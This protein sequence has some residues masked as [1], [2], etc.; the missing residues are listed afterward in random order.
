VLGMLA[1]AMAALVFVLYIGSAT[2]AQIYAHPLRL[3]FAVP[4]LG[5]WLARLWTLSYQRRIHEDPLFFV[6][7]DPISLAL[8]A[9]CVCAVVA[10]AR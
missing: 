2:V 3:W 4:M 9:G 5:A 7:K 8:I 6:S 10:A 1:S